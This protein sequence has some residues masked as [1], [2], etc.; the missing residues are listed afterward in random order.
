MFLL[1]SFRFSK[2]R[3]L[4]GAPFAEACQWSP[5]TPMRALVVDKKDGSQR[6]FDL[7]PGCMFH[8][9]NAW[10]DEQGVIRLHYMRAADP[11]SLLAGWSVMRGEY[12]HRVG[13]KLTSLTLG[14]ATGSVEQA[15]IEDIESEFPVIAP[16]LAGQRLGRILCVERSAQRAVDTP[17]FDQIALVDVEKGGGQRF[18]YGADWMV[19]EHLL[20]DGMG[21]AP[22]SWVVGT[23]LDLVN[24]KTVLSVFSAL[25]LADGPVFQGTLPYAL[26]LGLH[27]TFVSER[28][29]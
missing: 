3:M 23:A 1:P 8:I 15:T 2:N 10:E 13:A 5:A 21:S 28:R 29:E 9:A 26:P 19:E 25:S 27:G 18:R 20:V 4:E 22:T 17:G 7:P 12:V 6:S 11:L 16:E 14:L 24:R